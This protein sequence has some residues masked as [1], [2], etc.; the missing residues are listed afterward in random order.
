MLSTKT[1][2]GA[3]WMVS[4]RLGGRAIDVVTVLVLARTLTPADFGLTALA[5]TLIAV[6]DT[7]LEI[8]LMQALI[9][10]KS[11]EKSHLDTAFTLGILRGLLLSVV[12]L[13]A[14]WPFSIVFHDSRL[15]ALVAVLALGPISRS[16]YSPAMVKFIQQMSFR[17]AFTAEF[18]GKVL[19]SATGIL[20]VYLGGGYWAIAATSVVGSLA[21]TLI[22][23]LL[24][25]YR[26]AFSLS[27]ISDFSSFLGWFS[28]A[29]VVSALSWQFDRVLL[30]YFVTKS[31]LGQYTMATDLA[32]LPT[33]SLVG[34]A[35]MP[36]MAA[37]SKIRD[38]RERLRSAYLKASR[39]TMLLAVPACVG[40]SLTADLIINALLGG[41][42]WEEAAIYLQWLAL[43]TVLSAYFSPLN[44]LALA[45]NR[46]SILFRLSFIELCFR[47]VVI[48]IGLY[49]YG[50][51]GAVAAR[52]AISI[53]MFIV[54]LVT[55]RNLIGIR[56]AV[57]VGN[58]WKVAVS[59]SVMAL[60]VLVLRH[61]LAG[62]AL[63]AIVELGVTAAL[64]AAVYMGALF[65]LGV[66]LKAISTAVVE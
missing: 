41:S 62:R 26:P 37:F 28:S 51:L 17:Q 50:M 18:T 35:M 15:T 55:A 5:M 52:G 4:A 1:I 6:A 25:P 39:F 56:M 49:F 12:V 53:I 19:A 47:I 33:Q 38:D 54:A 14:A 48:P 8:P 2:L 40:M 31:Q 44:S 57:E 58:L 20:L 29:Q 9:R 10:V 65:V 42:K 7:V 21:A 30:G 59:C 22:T 11:V 36:V 27:N 66:R 23:Y 32:I 60:L 64:G 34:P 63:Y 45:I 3:S 43:A 13:S 16:L 46:P 24:A 61:E